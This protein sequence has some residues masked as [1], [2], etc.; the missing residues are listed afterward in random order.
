M[1][2]SYT[3][4][5]ARARNFGTGLLTVLLE[6]HLLPRAFLVDGQEVDVGLLGG[7]QEAQSAASVAHVQLQQWTEVLGRQ[8][9][10]V[11]PGGSR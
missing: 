5:S 3:A 7:Q 2:L 9:G 8:G 10:A 6:A 11:S 4:L 1:P